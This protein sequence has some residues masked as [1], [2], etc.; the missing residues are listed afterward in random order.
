M[1]DPKKPAPPV[2]STRR[3]PQ[4][5][6]PSFFLIL[7]S[8]TKVPGSPPYPNREQH[9]P[10]KPEPGAAVEKGPESSGGAPPGRPLAGSGKAHLF[11]AAVRETQ[12]GPAQDARGIIGVESAD[13]EA[14]GLEE[15]A[16]LGAR[17]GELVEVPARRAHAPIAPGE[18][19]ASQPAQAIPVGHRHEDGSPACQHPRR[20]GED[21]LGPF[22]IVLDDTQRDVGGKEPVGH[23]EAAGSA[24]ARR[25]RSASS[26]GR[27][28]SKRSPVSPS[29]MS[30]RLPAQSE[31]THGTPE[32]MASRRT[33]GCPSVNE[34]RT[35]TSAE[36]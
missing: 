2:T 26:S 33:L 6:D 18:E 17:E 11:P 31:A 34:A 15:R 23:A 29:V 4:K 1:K 36:P 30:D 19:G 28:G 16:Q 14:V 9:V 21:D 3:V 32:A 25:R 10:E 22:R 20:L 5:L 24:R 8:Y 13:G 12:Q 7:E 35:K 27:C